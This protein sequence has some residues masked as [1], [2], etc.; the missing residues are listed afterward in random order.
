[1][2]SPEDDPVEGLREL[3]RGAADSPD[4]KTVESLDLEER[5][6]R[7][8]DIRADRELR[9]NYALWVFRLMM[10]QL[11][12]LNVAFLCVGLEHL[13]YTDWLFHA[14]MLGTFGEVVGLVWA[15]SAYL[16]PN[17]KSSKTD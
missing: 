2:D 14:F 10:G 15:I 6:E 4:A 16:F 1:M 8:E 12:V 5:G 3:L 7:L 17:A 9:K 13:K 11:I